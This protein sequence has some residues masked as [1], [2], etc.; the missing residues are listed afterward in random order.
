MYKFFPVD[1][2]VLYKSIHNSDLQTIVSGKF[3]PVIVPEMYKSI[4]YN[5]LCAKKNREVFPGR[6]ARL[7]FLD[8][9][10]PTATTLPF[11]DNSAV[12]PLTCFDLY[13][14]SYSRDITTPAIVASASNIIFN[15]YS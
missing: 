13:T 12:L 5:G 9:I 7:R 1:M 2:M 10:P 14:M 6:Y 3:F 4:K 15:S 8:Y 11:L